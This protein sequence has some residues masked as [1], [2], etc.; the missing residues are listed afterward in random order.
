M[1]IA[2]RSSSPRFRRVPPTSRA[3]ASFALA[4]LVGVQASSAGAPTAGE[5]HYVDRSLGF[6]FSKPRFAPSDER[7]ASTVAITLAGASMGSLAP[8]VNVVVQN[9]DTT[10]DAYALQQRAELKA[11]DWELLE[12]S[13]AKIGRWPALRTHA[14]GSLQ[15]REV[16]FLAIAAMRD[17]KQMFVLT[18]TAAST[19]FPRYAAEFERVVTS[20]SLEP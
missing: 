10:I 7:G 9:L 8:S 5:E 19:E 1:S 12:Q 11:I 3:I 18:C 6:S 13:H 16:E 17:E 4:A 2:R 15:G 20:F 14:R